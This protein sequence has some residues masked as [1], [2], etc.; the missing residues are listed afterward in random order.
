[1]RVIRATIGAV[2]L[3][4]MG[5]LFSSVAPAEDPVKIGVILPYSGVYASL[6]GEIP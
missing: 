5:L 6:G 3:L 1:M 4:A 2:G